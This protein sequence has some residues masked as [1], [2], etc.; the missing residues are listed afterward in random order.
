M[1]FG[2]GGVVIVLVLVWLACH[3]G[4]PRSNATTKLQ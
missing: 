2:I 1:W 4:S 3:P